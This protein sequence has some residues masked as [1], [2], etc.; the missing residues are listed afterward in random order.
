MATQKQTAAARRNV[1][2]A[3]DA[4]RRKRTI[5]N[6]PASTRRDLGHQAAM[7]RSRGG[8]A[9]H[10]YE[11]RT[12]E[13]LYE[14]AQKRNIRGRSKMGKWELIEALRRTG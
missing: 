4:A 8:Q 5:A 6:L 7:A 3:K 1:V 13:Q 12:R 10:A 9:G 2:K 14:A 11:D